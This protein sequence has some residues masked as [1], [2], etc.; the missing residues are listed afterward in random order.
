MFTIKN[1]K[2]IGSFGIICGELFASSKSKLQ[3]DRPLPEKPVSVIIKA[4]P[5]FYRLLN[6]YDCQI[7][8]REEE[9]Q[10]YKKVGDRGA[11]FIIKCIGILDNLSVSQR[12]IFFEVGEVDLYTYLFIPDTYE[13]KTLENCA[14]C[15]N[16]LDLY[17]EMVDNVLPV[18]KDMNIVYADWKPQNIIIMPS[19]KIKLCDFG[20]VLTVD[21][22]IRNPKQVNTMFGSPNLCSTLDWITP[23]FEDDY[24]S[25]SFLYCTLAGYT[26]PWATLKTPTDTDAGS[27]GLYDIIILMKI[28]P[29]L[30]NLR[31]I[32]KHDRP[33]LFYID[34]SV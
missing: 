32:I 18:F 34:Q 21:K 15:A 31:H 3:L 23:Y 33:W 8:V 27:L 17:V 30:F 28:V 16:I 7:L 4:Q 29:H 26:L 11:D 14:L 5:H 25:A 6:I 12:A 22:H 20:S 9:I 1:S 19:K 13:K 2:K 24:K 10:F